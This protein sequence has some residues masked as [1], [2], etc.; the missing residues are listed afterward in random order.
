MIVAEDDVQA[1]AVLELSSLPVKPG[2]KWHRG[3]T[4]KENEISKMIEDRR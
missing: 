1:R 4:V 3:C 2:Y